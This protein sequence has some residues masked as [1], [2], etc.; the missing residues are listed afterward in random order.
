MQACWEGAWLADEK[1]WSTAVEEPVDDWRRW[2]VDVTWDRAEVTL[3]GWLALY[4]TR[5]C[6]TRSEVA[7]L[8]G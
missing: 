1:A 3:A 4:S 2:D 6:L 5:A 8:Q 7:F